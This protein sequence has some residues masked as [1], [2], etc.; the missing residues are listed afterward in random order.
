[1]RASFCSGLCNRRD[2][3]HIKAW[4]SRAVRD[5]WQIA[6]RRKNTTDQG[7]AGET[8]HVQAQG[9]YTSV[10]RPERMSDPD[11]TAT[12]KDEEEGGGWSR[13]F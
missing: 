4:D 7:A 12:L 1:M 11:G 5:W 6:R 9:H 10:K 13:T 3:V 8:S 2:G